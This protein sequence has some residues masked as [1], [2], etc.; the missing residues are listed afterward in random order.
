MLTKHP[1][2]DPPSVATSPVPSV[3]SMDEA[4]VLRA[5]RSSPNGTAPG[6]LRLRTNHLKEAVLIPSPDHASRAL[7]ALTGLV[8][9][10]C[11]GEAS[12]GMMP[13][14]CG[15]NLFASKK[16]GGGLS[17]IAI[18]EVIQ[19]LV[20]KCVSKEVQTTALDMLTPLKLGI[21]VPS[22]CEAIV[23]AVSSV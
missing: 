16:K 8:N 12:M 3:R 20:C 6:P 15:A 5:L 7:Q 1:Q 17:P 10:L 13:H 23:H 11:S 9:A 22:K 14:L 21:G 4:E 19:R 18:G 2:V